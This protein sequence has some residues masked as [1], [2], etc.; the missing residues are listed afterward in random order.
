MAFLL[1]A[2]R[3]GLQTELDAFFDHALGHDAVHPPTKSAVCQSR[4]QLR[5]EAL[6]DLLGYSARTFAAQSNISLWHGHRV[7]ALDGTTLRM[8]VFQ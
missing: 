6:R 8:C 4:S 5:P 7:V 1:N 2:P 3:A